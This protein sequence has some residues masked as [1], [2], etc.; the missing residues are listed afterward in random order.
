MKCTG[1]SGAIWQHL[2]K[3]AITGL[4]QVRGF[5]GETS[6]PEQMNQRVLTDVFYIENW[7]FLL[8]IKIILLTVWN[9]MRGEKNAY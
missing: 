2:A 6:D 8:D 9:M 7:S 5:R 3:P 1:T 4:S